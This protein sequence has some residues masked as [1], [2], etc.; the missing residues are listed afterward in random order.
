MDAFTTLSLSSAIEDDQ[1][2][3]SEKSTTSTSESSDEIGLTLVDYESKSNCCGGWCV[4]A[5]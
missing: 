4:I 3:T 5:W 2:F 1:I